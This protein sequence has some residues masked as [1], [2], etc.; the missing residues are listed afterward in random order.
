MKGYVMLWKRL[1]KIIQVMNVYERD[2][3]RGLWKVKKGYEWIWKAMKDYE[4]LRKVMK[5]YEYLQNILIS[6]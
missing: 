5:G 3:E 6:S 1:W 4:W 2:Y